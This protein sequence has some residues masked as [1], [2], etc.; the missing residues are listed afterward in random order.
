MTRTES[1]GAK[2]GVGGGEQ[3]REQE[4]APEEQRGQ[5]ES[6][7]VPKAAGGRI[8]EGA[9]QIAELEAAGPVDQVVR[10]GDEGLQVGHGLAGQVVVVSQHQVGASRAIKLAQPKHFRSAELTPVRRAA[11]G[12]DRARARLFRAV[13]AARQPSWNQYPFTPEDL[14]NYSPMKTR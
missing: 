11:S 7:V 4:H 12:E 3:S 10:S 1:C 9:A 14:I 6:G 8:K 13:R 5:A 2:L